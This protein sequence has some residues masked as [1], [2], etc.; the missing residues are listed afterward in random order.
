MT[1]GLDEIWN[2][3]AHKWPKWQL[4][5]CKWQVTGDNWHTQTRLKSQNDIIVVKCYWIFILCSS[6]ASLRNPSMEQ[7]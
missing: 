7:H 3:T 2:V 4:K 1:G 6:Q 5:D